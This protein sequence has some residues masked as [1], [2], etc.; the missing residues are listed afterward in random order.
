MRFIDSATVFN[1]TPIYLHLGMAS[2]HG[3]IKEDFPDLSPPI[4]MVFSVTSCR[5]CIDHIHRK[6]YTTS[7]APRNVLHQ[8]INRIKL[9]TFTITHEPLSFHILLIREVFSDCLREL[10]HENIKYKNLE[11]VITWEHNFLCTLVNLTYTT[12]N[13]SFC[14]KGQK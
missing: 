10:P 1:N 3:E 5:G 11:N 14:Q 8:A 9:L 13:N 2:P 7:F 12:H 4:V 6:Q